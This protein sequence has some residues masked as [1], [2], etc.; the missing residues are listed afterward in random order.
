MLLGVNGWGVIG[1]LLESEL[2]NFPTDR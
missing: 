2:V 1:A